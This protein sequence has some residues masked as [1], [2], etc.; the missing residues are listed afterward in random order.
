MTRAKTWL[1]RLSAIAFA[2][3]IVIAMINNAGW[4]EVEFFLALVSFVITAFGGI[5]IGVVIHEMGHVAFATIGS[6]PLYRIV[7]GAGPL[8]YC[9]RFGETWLEVRAWPLSGR[10]VP[11]PVMNYC[12][13]WWALFLL[14]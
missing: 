2:N 10:V 1:Q 8:L 13:N 4:G 9:R 6:I 3:C 7:I 11:Y 14:G 5:A 12:W